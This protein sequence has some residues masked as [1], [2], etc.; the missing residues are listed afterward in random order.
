MYY[1]NIYVHI[2]KLTFKIEDFKYFFF[3]NSGCNISKKQLIFF[4]LKLLKQL[5]S[6]Y[7]F[8]I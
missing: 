6:F 7:D 2:V 4:D 3:I 5:L 8:I 1:M